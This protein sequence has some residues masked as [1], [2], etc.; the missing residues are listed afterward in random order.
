[1]SATLFLKN[2]SKRVRLNKCHDFAWSR[3]LW[4][5]AVETIAKVSMALVGI[6]LALGYYYLA[7][8]DGR[9]AV[10]SWYLLSATLTT[11]SE[12]RFIF[13]HIMAVLTTDVGFTGWPWRYCS[14]GTINPS[15]GN[16]A[17][18]I[19]ACHHR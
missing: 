9:S 13:F 15:G 4:A 14:I 16:C 18:P 12:A 19:R 1:L 2:A 11:V 7:Y 8:L 17:D 3:S 5:E 6:Y 10:D